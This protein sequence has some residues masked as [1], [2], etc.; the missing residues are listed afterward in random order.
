MEVIW[1][2]RQN[3]IFDK[4]R[5]MSENFH[6]EAKAGS[7][8]TSTMVEIANRS[9][10]GEKFLF[11]A[12][13]KMIAETLKKKLP[14]ND[15]STLHALGYSVIRKRIP[16]VR[17]WRPD[18]YK[19]RDILRAHLEPIK[20]KKKS[21]IPTE[22]QNL[23]LKAENEYEHGAG[24]W[25]ITEVISKMMVTL[26]PPDAD[27]ITAM[28]DTYN[29]NL[30]L[31]P[32]EMAEVALR[33]I[34]LG[35]EVLF[36]AGLLDFNEMIYLPVMEGWRT[37]NYHT[38]GVD[39]AQDLNA[40]Q[41]ALL[42]LVR[43]ERLISVGDVRQSIFM[44]AGALSD[45]VS[46]LRV[47][48]A[49]N[50]D[51]QMPELPLDICY[52]CDTDIVQH[53]QSIVPDIKAAP[54]KGRGLVTEIEKSELPGRLESGAFILCRLNAP[55]V[56]TCF[57]LIIKGIAAKIRGKD[58]AE[59]LIQTIYYIA[60][61][62]SFDLYNFHYHL[63]AYYDA[64]SAKIIR[65]GGRR[66]KSLLTMLADKV[67]CLAA[68]YDNIQPSQLYELTDG[69]KA[70]FTN[71]SNSKVTLMSCH[72][73]KGL[74]AKQV[75]LIEPDKLP[76][77]FPGQTPEEARQEMNLTYVARTRAEHEFV[78]VRNSE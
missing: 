7:G 25:M 61:N 14:T 28:A 20:G 58:V 64:E 1:S 65:R 77:A 60:K 63:D 78:Y 32:D 55:L 31:E 24:L 41:Q 68:F 23:L 62:K 42:G 48:F 4:A 27:A 11:V 47:K 73:S 17:K 3:V 66:E 46:R 69:I 16:Q 59:G 51:E 54:W 57:Q 39:E 22:Y 50:G 6:I 12:F 38:I 71:D 75:F 52:R 21:V 2:D 10:L 37:G 40:A 56:S 72:K 35:R 74:E 36:N 43:A 49:Q 9:G 34:A 18:A 15:C 19:Y 13:S 33:T 26:T 29:V 44:F 53:A 70:I 5:L 45:S 76:L 67:R 30:P 8:K